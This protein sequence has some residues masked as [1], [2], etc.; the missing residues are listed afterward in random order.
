MMVPGHRTREH[1]HAQPKQLAC[2]ATAESCDS[3]GRRTSY[4]HPILRIYIISSLVTEHIQTIL[5]LSYPYLLPVTQSTSASG[6]L[7]IAMIP[8]VLH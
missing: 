1:A 7:V 4:F 3:R 5:L 8:R 2:T 6:L